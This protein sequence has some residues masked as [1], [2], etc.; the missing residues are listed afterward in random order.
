MTPPGYKH[1]KTPEEQAARRTATIRRY[2]QTHKE[3]LKEQN[4]EYRSRPEVKEKIKERNAKRADHKKEYYRKYAEKHRK[5]VRE[6]NIKKWYGLTLKDWDDIFVLQGGKC[7]ICQSDHPGNRRGGW[8]GDHDHKTG[9]F[10]G[11]LCNVCNVML[12]HAKDDP[13]IL[14]NAIDYLKDPPFKG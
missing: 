14:Q 10:R 6:R 12:G 13:E 1:S 9:K 4:K 7:A 3:H 5:R 8:S 2:Y 11:I